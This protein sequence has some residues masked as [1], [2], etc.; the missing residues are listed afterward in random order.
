MISEADTVLYNFRPRPV[1]E[2]PKTPF[3]KLHLQRICGTCAHYGG[4]LREGPSQAP[5][6]A[7]QFTAR[8]MGDAS[9]C[10][11]WVRKSAPGGGK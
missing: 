11:R 7:L 4:A 8:R 10:P 6:A 9:D 1:E 3:C 5:C 2:R